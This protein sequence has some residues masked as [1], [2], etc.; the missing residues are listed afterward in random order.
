MQVMS[1]VSEIYLTSHVFWTDR[2][3]EGFV[4]HSMN[5][6]RQILRCEDYQPP[7]SAHVVS[8]RSPHPPSHPTLSSSPSPLPDIWCLLQ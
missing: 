8:G 7:A 6:L 1:C 4:I 3:S 2:P 5:L